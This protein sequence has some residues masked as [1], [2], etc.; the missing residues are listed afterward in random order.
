M[1]YSCA[2]SSTCYTCSVQKFT[3]R[4]SRI[5]GYIT[6][7]W[8]QHV[9][10]SALALKLTPGTV[11]IM[12]ASLYIII[13]QLYEHFTYPNTLWSQC[14]WISDLLLQIV[15]DF[16]FLIKIVRIYG[17]TINSP[18][19]LTPKQIYSCPKPISNH[20]CTFVIKIHKIFKT[21]T[22]KSSHASFAIC[23]QASLNCHFERP[24]CLTII[25]MYPKM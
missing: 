7:Q 6:H 14:V 4:P 11:C 3:F 24:N 17:G 1:S 13:H 8:Q 9:S 16:H 15:Q 10:S 19:T 22:A 20:Q 18:F 21:L 5:R 12:W 25:I 23:L 2:H